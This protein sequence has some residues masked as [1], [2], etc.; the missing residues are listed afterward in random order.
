MSRPDVTVAPINRGLNTVGNTVNTRQ[1]CVQF[2]MRIEMEKMC[3][4]QAHSSLSWALYF[5]HY[6]ISDW[7]VAREVDPNFELLDPG[8]LFKLL[9]RFYAEVRRQ[10]NSAYSASSMRC[11]RAAIQRHLK[12]APFNRTFNIMSDPIFN[13]A[14]KV[15]TAK[16]KLIKREGSRPPKHRGRIAE[17]DLRKMMES[18]ALEP[19]NPIGLQ[20]LVFVYIAL[21]FCRRGREGLH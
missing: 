20:R 21:H 19:S 15:Y 6:L 9:C 13:S 11:T 5:L 3:N 8:E 14:N 18:D 16:L 12:S 1:I 4:V 2:D 7:C 10:D 17:G